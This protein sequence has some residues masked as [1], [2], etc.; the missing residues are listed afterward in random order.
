MSKA[1]NTIIIYSFYLF[2]MGIGLIFLPHHLLAILGLPR[3]SDSWI[4]VLGIFTFTAGIYYFQS[5]RHEQKAFF[6]A[7][8][9][10]RLFFFCALATL[11]IFEHLSRVFILIGSI[12]L[13][14]AVWT[15]LALRRPKTQ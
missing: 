12:D 15:W 2:I 6:S 10:G 13:I 3:T 14:G 4:Q 5:A 7:T 11:T 1:A 8:V 9:F